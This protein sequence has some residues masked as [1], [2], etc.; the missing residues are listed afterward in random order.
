MIEFV[1]L[2]DVM[3]VF[4][5]FSMPFYVMAKPAGAS[6]N[7]ACDYCYYLEKKRLYQGD[8]LGKPSFNMGDDMLERFTR[9]YIESQSMPAVLFTWHGGEPLMRPLSFYRRAVE[10]QRRMRVDV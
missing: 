7:L 9:S 10:L 4:T 8:G 6:C 2:C 5:P 1:Y 3:N